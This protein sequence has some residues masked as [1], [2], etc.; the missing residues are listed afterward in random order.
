MFW[1]I[2]ANVSFSKRVPSSPLKSF[3]LKLLS[4]AITIKKVAWGDGFGACSFHSTLPA[5][6]AE[7]GN[8]IFNK[9]LKVAVARCLGSRLPLNL[10]KEEEEKEDSC[11]RHSGLLC[12]WSL[13]CYTGPRRCFEGKI[14]KWI[15]RG[16]FGSV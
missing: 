9:K 14:L 4:I 13:R 6:I 16:G 11:V 10:K 12:F 7:Y 3:N 15:E 2:K 5:G 1:Q 8:Q